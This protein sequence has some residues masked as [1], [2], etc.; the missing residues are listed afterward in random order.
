V[1]DILRIRLGSLNRAKIEALRLGLAPFFEQVEVEPVAV[2]S[3][4]SE[5]PRG[6]QEILCGARNRARQSFASGNCEL[7]AGIEDGLV[8]VPGVSS[9]YMNIGYCVLF[10]G[11]SESVGLSAGFEYPPVCVAQATGENRVPIGRAF[12]ACFRPP[13]DWP[14]PC[15]G[16]GNIGR[17]T[18]GMLTRSHYGAQAVTCAFVRRLHPRL[19]EEGSL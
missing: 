17:L 15:P 2:E 14:D 11:T 6:F 12:D 8:E 19:Y 16:E 4:V 3:K 1:S 5:Q 13:P 9:G 7:A 10:D 18:G